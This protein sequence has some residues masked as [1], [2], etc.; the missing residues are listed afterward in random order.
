MN[1]AFNFSMKNLA[2]KL[3]MELWLENHFLENLPYRKY[4]KI[5]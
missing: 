5:N 3:N 2:I 1:G 4:S